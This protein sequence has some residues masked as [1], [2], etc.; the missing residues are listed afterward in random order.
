M[1]EQGFSHVAEKNRDRRSRGLVGSSE[2]TG[3]SS[4]I[5]LDLVIGYSGVA[6]LP[7]GAL[8][9]FLKLGG[10]HSLLEFVCNFSRYWDFLTIRVSKSKMRFSDVVSAL[11]VTAGVVS[12]AGHSGRS[13]KH[14]GKADKPRKIQQRDPQLHQR[15]DTSQYLTNSTASKSFD[16]AIRNSRTLSYHTFRVFCQWHRYPGRGLRHWRI[17]CWIDANF[18]SCQ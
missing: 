8:Q 6:I 11:A 2:V 16:V 13:L 14:V 3:S 1:R 9:P 4:G 18:E 5:V 7:R 15:R 10:P 12:A 17:V